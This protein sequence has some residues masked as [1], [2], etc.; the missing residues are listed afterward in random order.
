MSYS[1]NVIQSD[2]IVAEPEPKYDAQQYPLQKETY[3]L[4]GLCMEI[5]RTLGPGLAEAL[6]KDA[7]EV[8]FKLNDILYE[9]ERKYAV[10][11]KGVTLKHY[12]Y[13]DLVVNESIIIEVKAQE[14][15]YESAA[16]QLI[17]YLTLAKAPLGL[18]INFGERSLQY[19][20]IVFD[21]QRN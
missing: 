6:Y 20:R 13:A 9:R 11:C 19:K 12:Y 1:E 10:T 5:H 18:L 16:P 4:I 21:S 3:K 2:W 14:R 8:E 17:N 15:G 7:M